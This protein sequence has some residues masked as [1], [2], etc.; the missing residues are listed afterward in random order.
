MSQ[1]PTVS[2]YALNQ[3]DPDSVILFACRLAEKAHQ[4]H[5]RVHI[6]TDSL[7][8]ANRLDELLWQFKAESF[9]PHV[10][11]DEDQTKSQSECKITLDSGANVPVK[12]DVLINLAS[13]VWDCHIEFSDIREVVS[14]DDTSR[15]L[16]RQRYRYYQSQGYDIETLKL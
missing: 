4:L 10:N 5:H 6:H 8:Q 7:E 3:V 11:L 13:A 2:F 16:G 12:P 9:L 15:V 1:Q 14:G